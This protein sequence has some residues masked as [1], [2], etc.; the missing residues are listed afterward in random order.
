MKPQASRSPGVVA[1]LRRAYHTICIWGLFSHSLET[2]GLSSAA[3]Q[4]LVRVRPL[5]TVDG[6]AASEAARNVAQSHVVAGTDGE[7]QVLLPKTLRN[8]REEGHSFR[9]D[10]VAPPEATQEDV[11]EKVG[12]EATNAF[13]DGFNAAVFAYV[14][15]F[16]MCLS[17]HGVTAFYHAS[18]CLSC[19]NPSVVI[20][21][22]DMP[23]S[24]EPWCFCRRLWVVA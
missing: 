17:R 1:G 24:L 2:D 9:F 23:L 3:F 18:M 19:L 13:L 5:R 11:F 14:S 4:V 15:V 22:F 20:L 8:P 10:D 6:R 16:A 7:V 12:R 21:P